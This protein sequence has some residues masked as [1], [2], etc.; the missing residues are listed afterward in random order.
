MG[1]AERSNLS[2]TAPDLVGVVGM[3]EVLAGSSNF[4]SL[5]PRALLCATQR[6]ATSRMSTNFGYTIARCNVGPFSHLNVCRDIAT[7]ESTCIEMYQFLEAS[8]TD[9]RRGAG[10]R[11]RAY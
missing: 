10:L 9:K 3:R 8:L 1:L 11:W 4:M 7:S 5:F 2:S 6:P